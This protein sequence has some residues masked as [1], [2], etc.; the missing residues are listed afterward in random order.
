MI[1][2]ELIRR[3]PEV[4]MEACRQRGQSFPVE[5]ILDLDKKRRSAISSADELRAKRN[6]A[7]KM[8]GKLKDKPAS[9]ISEMREVGQRIKPVSYTHLTLPT[10]DLV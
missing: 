2:I 9:L 5:K 7:S 6:E 3:N 8:L 4:L 1:D 10:S